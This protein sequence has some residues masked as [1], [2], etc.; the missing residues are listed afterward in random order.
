[1]LLPSLTPKE[2]HY[3]NKAESDQALYELLLRKPSDLIDF[4]ISSVIDE[5]WCVQH[6]EFMRLSLNYFTNQTFKDRFKIRFV[7]QV[8]EAIRKHSHVLMPFLPL[9][10][11]C[12]IEGGVK[13]PVNGMMLIS[14]SPLFHDAYQR[15]CAEVENKTLDLSEI[16]RKVFDIMLEV[17][18][19]GD[20]KELWK[21]EKE[22]L[23]NFLKYADDWEMQSMSLMIQ[24]VL[25]RY[26]SKSNCFKALIESNRNEWPILK[27]NAIRFINELQVGVELHASGPFQIIFEFKEFTDHSLEAFD[28]LNKVITH[29]ICSRSLTEEAAFSDVVN[30]CSKLQSLSIRHT[31]KFSEYLQDIPNN[32]KELDV[33]M[34]PWVTNDNIG[35]L[36]EI[37]PH[38]NSLIIS[39]NSQL[40]Y[41]GWTALHSLVELESLDISKCFAIDDQD[42]KL[43]ASS[44]RSLTKLQ[45]CELERVTDVGF[46]ELGRN[47]PELRHLDL[48]KTHVTDAGLLDVVSRC[49]QL[50]SLKLNRCTTLSEEGIWGVIEN[51]KSLRVIEIIGC[52]VRNAIFEKM[53][54]AF[55]F[56][57]LQR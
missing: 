55:P 30:R 29:L 1:M 52:D 19:K 2:L 3:T 47:L 39:S 49:P 46:Y 40:N 7:H 38:L 16:P 9:D 56:L 26:I 37:C 17:V 51:S 8:A 12:L 35:K 10:I 57:N 13:I 44:C 33:S 45:M 6:E 21:N 5:T 41:K 4:F 15:E 28:K 42:L 14:V 54:A 36:F 27:E 34:C 53:R 22:E 31:N 50:E 23:L 24:E 25:K 18:Y 11:E 20:I 48:T 43:I 32:L